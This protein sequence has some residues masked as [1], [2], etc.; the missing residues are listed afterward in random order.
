MSAEQSRAKRFKRNVNVLALD[1]QIPP[2]PEELRS[3]AKASLS[4]QALELSGIN[5]G[6]PI[7]IGKLLIIGILEKLPSGQP[8]INGATITPEQ[9]LKDTA[10]T[11]ST[12]IAG[13]V[14]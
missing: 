12:A 4:T 1:V 13:H 11:I 9:L 6:Y 3:N 14:R 2:D 8:G 7:A 10:K 5:N